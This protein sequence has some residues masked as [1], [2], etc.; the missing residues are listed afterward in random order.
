MT[1]DDVK[2]LLLIAANPKLTIEGAAR[3]LAERTAIDRAH[4]SSPTYA[5]AQ[6]ALKRGLSWYAI[7]VRTALVESKEIQARLLPLS[8]SNSFGYRD[9]SRRV[10]KMRFIRRRPGEQFA[11]Y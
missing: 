8:Y 1:S 7:A 4:L 9:E 11:T 6:G 5:R 2:L 3:Q 10:C